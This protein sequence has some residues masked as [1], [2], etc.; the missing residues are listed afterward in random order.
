[1]SLVEI[2]SKHRKALPQD[3][4]EWPVN[5]QQSIIIIFQGKMATLREWAGAMDIAHT[6]L[7]RRVKEMPLEDAMD[8]TIKLKCTRRVKPKDT[9]HWSDKIRFLQEPGSLI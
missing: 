8:K 1:M 9:R 6:S 2:V 3:R 5:H 7:R 4:V